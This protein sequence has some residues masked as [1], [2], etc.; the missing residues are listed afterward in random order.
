MTKRT[1]EDMYTALARPKKKVRRTKK[2]QKQEH[3]VKKKKTKGN[4]MSDSDD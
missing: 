1:S 3:E 2:K 4:R